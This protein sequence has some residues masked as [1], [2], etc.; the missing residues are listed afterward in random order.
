M[1]FRLKIKHLFVKGPACQ[2]I[3]SQQFPLSQ[4]IFNQQ[5]A[6]TMLGPNGGEFGGDCQ[7]GNCQAG[8]CNCQGANCA[9]CAGANAGLGVGAQHNGG[10][11][12]PGAT[13]GVSLCPGSQMPGNGVFHANNGDMD[14]G[15]SP[16]NF[17]QNFGP[18]SPCGNSAGGRKK[19][20]LLL[21]RKLVNEPTSMATVD[22]QRSEEYFEIMENLNYC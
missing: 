7:C 21:L 2:Q 4:N 10:G 18:S 12:C 3:T 15:A 8:A 9:N 13:G 16:F 11:G 17:A 22:G 20:A 19:R 14:G 6:G 5:P 1:S